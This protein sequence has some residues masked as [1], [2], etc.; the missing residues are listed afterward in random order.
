MT[1][2]T[3][4]TETLALAERAPGWREALAGLGFAGV[5]LPPGAA[6]RGRITGLASPLGLELALIEAGPQTLNGPRPDL[7]ET[8]WLA[9]LV[10][11]RAEL[12]SEDVHIRLGVGDLAFGPVGRAARLTLE[13]RG[14]LIWVRVPRMALGH[15]LIGAG[16]LPVGRLR[17]DEAL[18]GVL[19]GFL[20]GL[21]DR[22]G[23]LTQDDL[24][25]VEQALIELLV[26]V[27]AGLP[28]GEA[29]RGAQQISRV[30]QIVET[31]LP[32]PDLSLR[33]L[34]DASGLAP[35]TVQ[36]LLAAAGQTF[37]GYV[38]D[39]RLE[40]C[41]AELENPQMADQSIGE[42]SRRWG[43]SYPA[44]FSRAFRRAYGVS[45]RAWRRRS[46]AD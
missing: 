23:D 21:S 25:P 35:R 37:A 44:Y 28:G 40:R 2:W 26:A 12:C 24:R 45:P 39:R 5:D 4:S 18:P 43:F 41:R 30:S 22:L 42:I 31:L 11:G 36:K 38:R 27:L 14:R 34:A 13:T 7:P 8:L 20:I 16:A 19:S 1:A 9:A 17:A 10:E 29:A 15:R 33:R 32:D 6:P 46:A 3:F